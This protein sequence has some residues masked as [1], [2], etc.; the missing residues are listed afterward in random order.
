EPSHHIA[1]MYSYLGKPWKT[2]EK[3]RAIIDSMY[4]ERPDGYAGNED[5]GQM[6]AWA[7]WSM[8]GLYPASP[9]NGE[10]VFGS[11]ALGKSDIPIP[12]RKTFSI[13]AQKNSKKKMYIK[14]MSLDGKPYRN[15]Y[16]THKDMLKS[17]TVELQMSDVPKQRFGALKKSLP[18]SME[19]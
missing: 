8:M 5:A 3:V 4:H 12:N 14:S 16:I 1:Y 17:G 10:Y 6:S 19:S 15:T 13:I 18:T 9:V 7:V 2:Q 11:P